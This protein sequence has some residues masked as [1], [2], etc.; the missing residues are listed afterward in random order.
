LTYY[1]LSD[2]LVGFSLKNSNCVRQFSS[3][4]ASFLLPQ[5]EWTTVRLSWTDFDGY[6]WGAVENAMDPS[7]L[8]RIGVV[9][10]GKAMDATLGLSSIRFF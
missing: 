10:I 2:I 4:R 8:R 7:T 3:Y 9:A 1:V 6:G 5:G